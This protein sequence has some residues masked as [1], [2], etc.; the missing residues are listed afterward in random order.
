MTLSRRGRAWALRLPAVG[1]VFAY[2]AAIS[3][4]PA[5]IIP[6]ILCYAENAGPMEGRRDGYINQAGAYIDSRGVVH[7]KRGDRGEDRRDDHASMLDFSSCCRASW[8]HNALALVILLCE[9]TCLHSLGVIEHGTCVFKCR[10]ISVD[11][12]S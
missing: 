3:P 9:V 1:E 7:G 10:R 8:K 6:Y 12:Q 5:S 4:H 11:A 2:L